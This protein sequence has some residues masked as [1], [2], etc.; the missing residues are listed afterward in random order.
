VRQEHRD[1]V[2]ERVD[3]VEIDDKPQ[4]SQRI[5]EAADETSSFS[6]CRRRAGR[7]CGSSGLTLVRT[8]LST[9]HASELLPSKR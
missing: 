4:S 6:S 7:V 5:L 8:R 3:R 2:G 1:R 9:H